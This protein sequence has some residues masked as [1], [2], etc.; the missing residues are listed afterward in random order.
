MWLLLLVE[1]FVSLVAIWINGGDAAKYREA[2]AVVDVVDLQELRENRVQH[3]LLRVSQGY[4]DVPAHLVL[5]VELFLGLLLLLDD[6]G[7]FLLENC[8]TLGALLS[9]VS[10]L[11]DFLSFL[12]GFV[13]LFLELVAD[14][15]LV[16]DGV[17]LVEPLHII[18]S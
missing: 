6:P 1:H 16:L 17:V 15:Q 13:P 10:F 18:Q 3:L 11:R 4:H 7:K 12:H 8:L 9:F 14:F 2:L 5:Q